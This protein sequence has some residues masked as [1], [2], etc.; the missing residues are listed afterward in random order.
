MT[1]TFKEIENAY[2]KIKNSILKTPLVSNDYINEVTKNEVYFKLE[3]LQKTGSF[4]I[5][6]ATHKISTLSNEILNNGVVAYSSGNHAQAVAYAALKKN[7]SA[8]IIMP[9]NA[10]RIKI[11]NTKKYGADIILYDTFFENREQIGNEIKEKEQRYLIRPYDDNDII[12]GQGTVGI[13]I[14]EDLKNSAIIPDIYLCCCGGGGLVAGSSTYLQ[15]KYPNL[16]SYSVEPE[17]F[18]DTKKSLENKKIIENPLNMISICD[19]LLAP[20]PGN[21]TFPINLKNLEGGITVTDEEVKKTIILLSEHLKIVA[22]P[23][24][25][26]AAAALLSKKLKIK[27]KKVVVMISGGNI[28]L[29]L[30]RSL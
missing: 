22:E 23:G 17:G 9:T 1:I 10:P 3:N 30:F 18:D 5:R 4:K 13:E 11:E 21:I 29:E 16:K 19:A 27:N 2:S 14:Y 8:K 15:H 25:A 6:G 12:A 7:I 28:D 26:V 24:G 20:M